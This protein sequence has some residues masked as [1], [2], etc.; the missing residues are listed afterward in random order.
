MTKIICTVCPKGC[1]MNIDDN[2]TVTGHQCSRGEMYGKNELQNPVRV[3][4][5][6]VKIKNAIH[7]RCPVKTAEPIP[8]QLVPEAMCLLNNVELTAPVKIGQ[9]VI[10]NICGTGIPFVT[11][12][13][14]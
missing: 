14:M 13:S 6:T 11:S 3:I 12:R 4:T 5:S 9:V 8:K 7:R 1:H 10:P 2:L